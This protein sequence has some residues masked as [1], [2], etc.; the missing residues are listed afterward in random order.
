MGCH[1][2]CPASRGEHHKAGLWRCPRWAQFHL[3]DSSYSVPALLLL[4]PPAPYTLSSFLE[5]GETPGVW[6]SGRVKWLLAINRG[7]QLADRAEP[8]R[9]PWGGRCEPS[10]F[11][12]VAAKETNQSA[13]LP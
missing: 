4:P 6:D 10:T 9:A 8:H 2:P 5:D 13:H 1:L 12:L 11:V 7:A 3:G